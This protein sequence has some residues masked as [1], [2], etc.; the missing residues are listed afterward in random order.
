MNFIGGLVDRS[1][2]GRVEEMNKKRKGGNYPRELAERLVWSE[3]DRT[4]AQALEVL[5][6]VPM[7]AFMR[8]GAAT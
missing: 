2:D 1:V 6:V 4:G 5:E 3:V 8:I 7:L